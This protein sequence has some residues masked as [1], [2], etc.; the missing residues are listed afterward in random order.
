MWR[1]TTWAIKLKVRYGSVS[2]GLLLLLM[3]MMM[4]REEMCCA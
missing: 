3:M 2:I 4:M 1:L